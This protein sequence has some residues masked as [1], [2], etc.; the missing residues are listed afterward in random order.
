[1]SII[2]FTRSISAAIVVTSFLCRGQGII[3]TVAGTGSEEWR[4]P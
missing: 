1:M 4:L 3:T 2:T